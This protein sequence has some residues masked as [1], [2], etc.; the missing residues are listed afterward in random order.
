MKMNNLV[1]I[2]TLVVVIAMV[3]VMALVSCTKGEPVD[4]TTNEQIEALNA[5]IESL[6][7][8]LDKAQADASAE[9]AELEAALKDA[10]ASLE[11]AG[12]N[13]EKWTEATANI[14]VALEALDDA[15]AVIYDAYGFIDLDEDGKYVDVWY[16]CADIEAA[17]K[18]A[19]AVAIDAINR[20]VTVEEQNAAIEAFKKA[21]APENFEKIDVKIAN[22]IAAIEAD[23]VTY[24]A[25]KEFFDYLK[26]DGTTADGKLK[27]ALEAVSSCCKDAQKAVADAKYQEKADKLE[28]EFI[29]DAVKVLTADYKAAMDAF[30]AKVTTM[31]LVDEK[32]GVADIRNELDFYA[33][34]IDAIEATTKIKRSLEK[35]EAKVTEVATLKAF[36]DGVTEVK[37]DDVA[38]SKDGFNA[39]MAATLKKFDDCKNSDLKTLKATI[40]GYKATIKGWVEADNTLADLLEIEENYNIIAHETIEKLDAAFADKAAAIKAKAEAFIKAVEALEELETVDLTIATLISDAKTAWDALEGDYDIAVA[41]N[42]F[43]D[44]DGDNIYD[45]TIEE[46]KGVYEENKARF[47]AIQELVTLIDTN[48][49][50][51]NKLVLVNYQYDKKDDKG[52]LLDSKYY[53]INNVDYATFV[54]VFSGASSYQNVDGNLADYIKAI[55]TAVEKLTLPTAEQVKAGADGSKGT[56]LYGLALSD[57]VKAEIAAVE[58]LNEKVKA[59]AEVLKYFDE[60]KKADTFDG[61][62]TLRK[63]IVNDIWNATT[64][65]AVSA[66]LASYETEYANAKTAVEK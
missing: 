12:I 53:S 22:L 37:T 45:K 48:V 25:D 46:Y 44:E 15:L 64:K 16:A 19:K 20:A 7:A 52:N 32:T 10:I 30:S 1:K 54:K 33:E 47:S 65:D 61:K 28:K 50:K 56:G 5:T 38:G 39:Q 51:A 59:I 11:Q 26:E 21:L 66:Q 27:A 2:I 40:D 18:A 60:T 34:D 9:N 55:T 35:Y 43:V 14:P 41:L 24:P 13:S 8:A 4:N 6:K 3:A 57:E 29:E 49:D 42:L 36:Y 17:A 31:A 58:L 23:G 63:E 62:E